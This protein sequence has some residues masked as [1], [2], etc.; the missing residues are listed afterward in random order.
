MNTA[1]ERKSV[2]VDVCLSLVDEFASFSY[3]TH[4]TL[5]NDKVSHK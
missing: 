2:L 4:P 5:S 3:N 1:E